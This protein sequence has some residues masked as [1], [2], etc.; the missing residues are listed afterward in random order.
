[1]DIQL[2][3]FV[4]A[5]LYKNTLVL[6][7]NIAQPV[8]KPPV[9]GTQ[10]IPVKKPEPVHAEQKKWF[11]GDN[12]RGI[13]LVVNDATAPFINDEWLDT[14]TKLLAALKITLA[15]TAIVNLPNQPVVFTELQQKLAVRHLFLFGVT[16]EQIQLPFTIPD[17]Q[18]QNFAGCTILKAPA[19]TLESPAKTTDSVK[20]EKRK[21]WESLKKMSF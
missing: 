5:E 1:M 8:A 14:L 9:Q 10:T 20:A 21:L 16:T 18:A 3:D 12:K 13:V 19:A 6:T 2:P 17:Y 7:T 15:D 11:L 4:L